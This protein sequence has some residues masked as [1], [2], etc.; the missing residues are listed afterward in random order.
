[1]K[2]IRIAMA[3][4]RSP[5]GKA[6]QNLDHMVS[7]IKEAARKNAAIICFPELNITGYSTRVDMA[8]AVQPNPGIITS[9]LSLLARRHNLT[10]LAGMAE[11]DENDRFF[12]SHMVIKPDATIGVY[13]KVHI[14]PTETPLFAP[15]ERIPLFETN[16]VSFGIQLCFDA[17]FPELSTH[18]A[19]NGADVIFIPHASPRGDS[20]D[21]FESWMRHL[22]ARA[23]DNGVFILACNQTGDNEH[24]L[25]FP[26]LAMIIA[27]TGRIIG[28]DVSGKEVIMMADLKAADLERVRSHRMAYFLPHRRPDLYAKATR[29]I[30][31][32]SLIP[33]SS[34][35][36]MN[37]QSMKVRA[38]EW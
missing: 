5:V 24:G 25:D 7:F 31:T 32:S 18:M 17:H 13:R 20:K 6:K 4:T 37:S 30:R 19:V 11:R 2:D 33:R 27:P 15:G 26:G 8:D 21:K 12:A 28:K 35:T 3:V 1:M 29:S 38:E 22:T 36:P 23:Y 9:E 14:S 34:K 10:I 16:G